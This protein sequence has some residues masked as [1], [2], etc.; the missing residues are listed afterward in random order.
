MFNYRRPQK[1]VIFFSIIYTF[2][3]SNV[4]FKL[5]YLF[6][7]LLCWCKI[8]KNVLLVTVPVM[9]HSPTFI[10]LITLRSKCDLTI[11]LNSH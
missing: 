3:K 1:K 2:N 6:I 7:F 10:N 9:T 5:I 8:K 4:F 11:L